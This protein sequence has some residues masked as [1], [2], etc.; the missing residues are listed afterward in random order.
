MPQPTW[1]AARAE[2]LCAELDAHGMSM[3]L[4]GAEKMIHERVQYVA[5]HSGVSQATARGYL[6]DDAVAGLAFAML[7]SFPDEEPGTDLLPRSAPSRSGWN[8]LA[9]VSR[10]WPRRCICT[11]KRPTWTPS[12]PPH[13]I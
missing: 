13:G 9:A 4:A 1:V 8:S 11:W 12:E 3:S 6:T 5:A 10:R 7:N 2:Q